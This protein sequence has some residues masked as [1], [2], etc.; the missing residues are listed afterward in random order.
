MMVLNDKC[1]K[2]NKICFAT[3]FQQN[4]VNWTSG[5]ND[6]DKFIQDSQLSVHLDDAASKALEWI[7][8]DRFYNIK[9]IAEAK[10]YKAKWIDGNISYWNIYDQNWIRRN[11]NII[12][13]LKSINNLNNLKNIE[14]EFINEV[15]LIFYLI[16][17]FEILIFIKLFIFIDQ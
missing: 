1:K 10:K 7:P 3:Y 8:Y 6:I 14:F 2:C 5:N 9:Y 15:Y 4:F 16:K 13:N 12:V 17:N 11:Q